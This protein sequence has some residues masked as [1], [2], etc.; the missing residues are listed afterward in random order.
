MAK[1]LTGKV[2]LVTGGSRGIGVVTARA[3]AEDVA[4]PV[5]FIATPAAGAIAGA[6]I[7]NDTSINA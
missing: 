5:T 1:N 3:L 6:A 7:T 2:A 4:V